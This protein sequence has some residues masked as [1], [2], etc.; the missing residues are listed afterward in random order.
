MKPISVIISYF[1]ALQGGAGQTSIDLFQ[2]SQWLVDHP[3][4][5]IRVIQMPL[6]IGE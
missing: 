5:L 2:L 1:D 3:G 4:C 6:V